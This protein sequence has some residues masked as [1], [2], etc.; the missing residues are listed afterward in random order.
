MK[1]LGPVVPIVT[2]CNPD[3]S[4]DLDGFRAVCNDMLDAGCKGIFVAGTTGR[5]PWF[6]LDDRVRLCQAAV[7]QIKGNVTLFAGVT[8]SGLPGMLENAKALADAG[9]QIAVATVPTYYHYN[10]TEIETIYAKFADASPLPVMVYDIPEFTNVKLGS[11]MLLRLASHGNII[12]FKDSSADL[13]RFKGL[14][15]ALQSFPD[16]YLMQGKENLIAESLQV[17]ASGFIVSLMHIDP[18]PF[19]GVYN[20]VRSGNYQLAESLQAEINKV[21][22]L[23]KGSIERRPESSTLFHMLNYALQKRGVCQNILLDHD[24]AAPDWVFE[25]A[26][27]TVE[28]CLAAAELARA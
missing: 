19:V 13:D 5:G 25:N 24:D 10:Q 11:G 7:E 3:G 17:G 22:L 1:D 4:P 2:P 27:Q 12:G 18:R 28:I 14:I 26:Q 8:S 6:S 15:D 23:V 20:A 21:I 16:F 9:A